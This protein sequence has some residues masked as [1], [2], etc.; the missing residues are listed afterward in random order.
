MMCVNMRCFSQNRTKKRHRATYEQVQG[1][2]IVGNGWKL[3]GEK[4]EAGTENVGLTSRRFEVKKLPSHSG[5]S[6]QL[7][8]YAQEG[9]VHQ[10]LVA[11][12]WPML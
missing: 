3:Q 2:A 5:S 1:E 8:K 12:F 10:D 11:C 9:G 7:T 4:M 6:M